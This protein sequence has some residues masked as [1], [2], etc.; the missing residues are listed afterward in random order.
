MEECNA[1][2][3]QAKEKVVKRFGGSNN[4]MELQNCSEISKQDFVE[5]L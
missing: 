5:A 4:N 2:I 1:A 3:Q